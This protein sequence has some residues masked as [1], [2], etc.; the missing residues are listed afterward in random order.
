MD[1]SPRG[2]SI[3][4]TLAPLRGPSARSPAKNHRKTHNF[5]SGGPISGGSVAHAC[6]IDAPR[7]VLSADTSIVAIAPATVASQALSRFLAETTPSK[8]GRDSPACARPPGLVLRL[9]LLANARADCDGSGI[10][11]KL[12]SKPLHRCL[13]R[14]NRSGRSRAVVAARDGFSQRTAALPVGRRCESGRRL[15]L[16]QPRPTVPRSLGSR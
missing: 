5:R 15:R 9:S 3:A 11:G 1:A 8:R 7:R 16:T 14:R 2:P 12:S 10:V 13:V 4:V 6:A